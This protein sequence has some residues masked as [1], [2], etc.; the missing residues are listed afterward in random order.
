MIIWTRWGI[1][2]LLVAGL[3]VGAGFLLKLL[4][5]LGAA[6]GEVSGVFVGIGLLLAA[7]GLV[8]VDRLLVRRLLDRPRPMYVTEQLAEP[9]PG[10]DGTLQR[11]RTVPA[12][13]PETG[14]PIVVVPRSTLFFI[15]LRFWPVIL[16]VLG[17]LT[18]VVN[19]VASANA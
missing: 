18:L 19:L 11:T 9:V 4:V 13:H 3:G 16:G 14:Q 10:P 15:P 17:A 6:T 12:V 8:V 5:G 1:L 2:A 7:G